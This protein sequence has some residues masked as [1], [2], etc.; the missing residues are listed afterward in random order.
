MKQQNMI[1]DSIFALFIISIALFLT[2]H[3]VFLTTERG[4]YA[5]DTL[6]HIQIAKDLYMGKLYIPHPLWHLCTMWTSNILHISVELASVICSTLFLTLWS[7]LVLYVVKR[8]LDFRF[9]LQ[10]IIVSLM[11]LIVGPLNI[12]WYDPIIFSGQGSPN[13]WHNVTLWAV[14]PF[15][16]LTIL[17][18]FKA[19]EDK[20]RFSYG[21]AALFLILSIFAKP[22]FVIMFLPSLF[23]YMLIYKSY[24]DKDFL[25]FYIFISLVSISI[26]SYQY[27]HTFGSSGDSHIVFDF[28]GVWS[29]SS[30]NIP[31]S[32]VLALAFPMFFALSQSHILND[33]YILI[34]W[35]QTFIA[36]VYYSCL[37]QSGKY[38]ADGNFGWS[39]VLAMSLLYLFSIV[40]FFQ[41]YPN[42][43]KI[44]RYL[45]LLLLILQVIIGLYFFIK[46]AEGYRVLA[47]SFKF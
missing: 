21:L 45:L 2:Y 17:F 40:K 5:S 36:L 19:I 38:Y 43:I 31:I 1:W 25:N 23:I 24:R 20:S 44:K 9:E 26:L 18:V 8:S 7:M 28:L 47:I 33:K 16:L 14:K 13:V 22:S 34:S 41:I 15:A 37:A 12:P 35:I 6:Q 10:Y 3:Q 39:Y 11:I 4:K 29:L 42:M 30:L 46:V 32:I 27:V